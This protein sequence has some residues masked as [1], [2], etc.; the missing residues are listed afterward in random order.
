M[1]LLSEA[2][3]HRVEEKV[4]RA[5]ETGDE[6]G[7]DV[8][9]YGEISCVIGHEVE[10]RPLALKRLPP[11]YDAE[12][13]A[14]YREVFELYF[15]TLVARG[16]K[17]LSSTLQSFERSDGS[18]AAWCVQPRLPA[19]NLLSK[20]FHAC[21]K[22][23]AVELFERVL[24]A[25]LACAGPTLGIDGQLS[26]WILDGNEVRYLDVT[27]PMLRTADG[28]E[29]LPVAVFLAS[30]PWA[31]R[32]PV[33][34]FMLGE[35]LDKYYDPRGVVLDLL[36]NLYKERLES[37]LPA[38]IERANA[39]VR[40]AID[41]AEARRYYS[42]DARSWAL[43]QRLRRADRWWQKRVRRRVYP[44]LLPGTIER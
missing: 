9:G 2:E 38:L 10:G 15:E 4:R 26:N 3:L 42:D 28:T 11:F 23:D 24:R 25:I 14:T 16:V 19:E 35:I 6:S 43:L 32:A 29:R 5:L 40:P 8:L 31:L 44:F 20:H 17:P 7:L 13:F 41:I 1:I 21:P 33:R 37:L 30:L 18:I 39:F 27:T 36:G 12:T 34:R 22:H